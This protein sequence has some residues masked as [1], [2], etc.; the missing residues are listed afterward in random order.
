MNIGLGDIL[1]TQGNY[2]VRTE[3]ASGKV[4]VLHEG[5]AKRDIKHVMTPGEQA[6][7]SHSNAQV[8]ARLLPST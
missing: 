5:I 2:P 4:V 3:G 8:K 6:K 7:V 1:S